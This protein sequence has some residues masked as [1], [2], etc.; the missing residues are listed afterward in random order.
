[1]LSPLRTPWISWGWTSATDDFNP[2]A[3]RGENTVDLC[4]KN[5]VSPDGESRG[6]HSWGSSSEVGN[7]EQTYKDPVFFLFAL[8][9]NSQQA[10]SASPITWV[11]QAVPGVGSIAFCGLHCAFLSVMQK[12]GQTHDKGRFAE[13]VT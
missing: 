7:K 8:F 4:L 12:E 13:R 2:Q 11:W 1:M 9:Q 5:C 10:V 3:G 6:S